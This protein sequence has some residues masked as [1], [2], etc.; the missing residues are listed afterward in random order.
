[1]ASDPK[2]VARLDAMLAG[3]SG[4]EQ[5][6]IFGGVAYMLR[7]NVCVGVY[8]DSLIVRAGEREAGTLL[9]R[10]HVRPMDITGKPLKGWIMV[11]PDGLRRK[12]DLSRYVDAAL[13]FVADLPAK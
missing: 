1:M 10:A 3:R 4:V 12:A 6:K 2:L 8:K 9:R 7:G 5:R 13:E 11:E